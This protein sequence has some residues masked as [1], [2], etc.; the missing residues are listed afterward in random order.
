M[1]WAHFAH[2]LAVLPGCWNVMGISTLLQV[3]KDLF[4]I[5]LPGFYGPSSLFHSLTFDGA[6]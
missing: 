1:S 5:I 4:A 6:K 2:L 3:F